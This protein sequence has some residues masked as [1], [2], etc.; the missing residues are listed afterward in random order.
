MWQCPKC[1]ST[2]GN[3]FDV[4]W[5]CGTTLDGIEDPD[6]VTADEGEPAEEILVR[7]VRPNV[8]ARDYYMSAGATLTDPFRLSETS[9]ENQAILV[10]GVPTV[11]IVQLQAGAV[12]TILPQ[13]K[14]AAGTEPWREPIPA[15]RDEALFRE[16]S[17]AV[18]ARR[19]EVSSGEEDQEG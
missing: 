5:A 10:D 3:S 7:V 9:I 12:V 8:G 14:K 15:F 2:V 19:D 16:Y 1:Q 6:F 18:K 11:E 4:C 13:A 17:D